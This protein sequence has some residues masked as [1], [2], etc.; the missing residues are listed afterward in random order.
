MPEE[1]FFEVP[2]RGT[3]QIQLANGDTLDA[4]RDRVERFGYVHKDVVLQRFASHLTQVLRDED[5]LPA[6]GLT[7]AHLNPVRALL[8]AVVRTPAVLGTPDMAGTDEDLVHIEHT[9][10]DA[11]RLREEAGDMVATW[12]ERAAALRRRALDPAT[13]GFVRE[14]L[15]AEAAEWVSAAKRLAELTGI[16]L[17]S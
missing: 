2:V 7:E 5:A 1:V 9:L 4:T 12:I 10:R 15:Q 13:G 16:E 14:T 3:L 17:P 6:G 11:Q 8:E